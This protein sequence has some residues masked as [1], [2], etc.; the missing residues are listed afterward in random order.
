MVLHV[1]LLQL[2]RDALLR[3]VHW[4]LGEVG[5]KKNRY[6]EICNSYVGQKFRRGK[7]FRTD[8]VTYDEEVGES[9]LFVQGDQVHINRFGL[10]LSAWNPCSAPGTFPKKCIDFLL[11]CVDGF[12]AT[13]CKS[14]CLPQ[15][16][17]S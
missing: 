11:N 15:P 14:F 8:M 9:K 17:M 13:Y 7:R 5:A 4:I 16:R 2:T 6:T 1:F 12:F 10:E 3:S